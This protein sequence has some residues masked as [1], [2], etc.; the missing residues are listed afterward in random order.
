MDTEELTALPGAS[1]CSCG[2]RRRD[3]DDD[4]RSSPTAR[5]ARPQL[6]LCCRARSPAWT[7]T[8]RT[9]TPRAGEP[10]DR[11]EPHLLPRA[12]PSVRRGGVPARGVVR[13]R[14]FFSRPRPLPRP[15]HRPPRRRARVGTRQRPAAGPPPPRPRRVRRGPC[16]PRP[17]PRRAPVLRLAPDARGHGDSQWSADA[18]YSPTSL[19]ADAVALILELHLYV[20]PILLVGFGMGATAALVLAARHPA[21]S[22]P[23]RWWR[24][25]RRA[26]GRVDLPAAGGRLPRRARA[27]ACAR[28]RW[29]RDARRRKLSP[30]ARGRACA[31]RETPRARFK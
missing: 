28:P 14:G 25:P 7:R 21:L 9:A 31:P 5:R 24:P 6:P 1:V 8:P 22:P 19:A 26:G 15:V 2:R 18:A 12:R 11:L 20:R 4:D 27:G 13:L 10:F 29:K 16:P 3:D 17:R 23:S 30:R